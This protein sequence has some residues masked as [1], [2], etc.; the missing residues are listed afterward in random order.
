MPKNKNTFDL[1]GSIKPLI[2]GG[3]RYVL[4]EV[5]KEVE[6]KYVRQLETKQLKRQKE[7]E[8]RDLHALKL[9]SEREA[10]S[11]IASVYGLEILKAALNG[12]TSYLLE[13]VTA[14]R[15][16]IESVFRNRGFDVY[17]HEGI[18]SVDDLDDDKREQYFNY[19]PS[20]SEKI[21]SNFPT[22]ESKRVFRTELL[23]K[24]FLIKRLIK[25]HPELNIKSSKHFNFLQTINNLF[26]DAH[27]F[28][29]NSL[30]LLTVLA[31]EVSKVPYHYKAGAIKEIVAVITEIS[32]DIKNIEPDNQEFLVFDIDWEG[33]NHSTNSISDCLEAKFLNWLS[34]EL[35]GNLI[36]EIFRKIEEASLKSKKQITFLGKLTQI[37]E[38]FWVDEESDT[39]GDN[40]DDLN[41]GLDDVNVPALRIFNSFISFDPI[42]LASMFSILGYSV[43]FTEVSGGDISF[44]IGWE[45]KF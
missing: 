34:S 29:D 38:Y 45:E 30:D 32:D 1:T 31:S 4:S 25:F 41:Q 2:K 13:D 26:I 9:Q 19:H 15:L 6:S 18:C 37:Q 10:Y 8:D 12:E 11:I 5:R 28:Q 21:I 36:K 3:K 17:K 23:N 43:E 40:D 7:R 39:D 14:P 35:G 33:F 22:D 44:N 24:L 16:S 20:V 27:F 42:Y